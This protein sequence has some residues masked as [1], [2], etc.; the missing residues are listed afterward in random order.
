M[1]KSLFTPLKARFDVR[2]PI[3]SPYPPSATSEVSSFESRVCLEI[4]EDFERDERIQ[5]MR[6]SVE[7]IKSAE[8]VQER[9]QVIVSHTV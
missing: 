2:N 1:F 5:T 7:D 9:L 8:S 4:P 6:Q 3:L